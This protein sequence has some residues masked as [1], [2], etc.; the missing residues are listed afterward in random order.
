[1]SLSE[2]PSGLTQIPS[3]FAGVL[4][5]LAGIFG[6]WIKYRSQQDALQIEVYKIL[7]E[8]RNRQDASNEALRKEIADMR[9]QLET[10]RGENWKKEQSYQ[11]RI[12]S[13]TQDHHDKIYELQTKIFKLELQVKALSEDAIAAG[14]TD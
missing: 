5:V 9:L 7:S 4:G 3:G 12:I 10:E 6:M 8:E 13:M 1:M 2:I 14:L 11:S